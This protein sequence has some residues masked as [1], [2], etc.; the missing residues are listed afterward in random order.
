V[1]GLVRRAGEREE[2]RPLAAL[3]PRTLRSRDGEAETHYRPKSEAQYEREIRCFA[4]ALD[5]LWE[6]GYQPIFV[7]MN[8][9]PPDDDRIAARTIRERARHGAHAL[10]VD[11]EVRPRQAPCLYGR[12]L[13]SF[14]ARV[15]GS[16]TS[17]LGGCPPMMYAF[18]PKHAG[19]MASMGLQDFVLREDAAAPE[20]T[21]AMLENLL[22]YRDAAARFFA[23]NLPLLRQKALIPAR[24]AVEI[25]KTR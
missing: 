9:V 14:V 16:V 8:T 11:E 21:T 10:L 7:P 15:H 22:A 5:W 25:L 6:H 12:C 19:I 18:A 1:D 3:T 23:E 4:A 17:A 13:V 24:L 2:S 20:T